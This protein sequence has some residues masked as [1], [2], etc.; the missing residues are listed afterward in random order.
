[1]QGSLQWTLRRKGHKFYVN[2]KGVTAVAST[3]RCGSSVQY[4]TWQ[5]RGWIVA[6]TTRTYLAEGLLSSLN[7]NL[8]DWRYSRV[9]WYSFGAAAKRGPGP[10]HYQGFTMREREREKDTHTHTHYSGGL[11]SDN[12]QH[13]EQTSVPPEGFE[14]AFSADLRL[15]PRGHWGGRYLIIIIISSSSSSS[16]SSIIITW[17]FPVLLVK[18]VSTTLLI[19]LFYL[20][21]AMLEY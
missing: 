16:S 10:P 13:S 15:I 14:P 20:W 6:A 2:C 19:R 5:P 4:I 9:L 21:K 7:M 11:I 1:M 8:S 3:D 17:L 12:T 18:L